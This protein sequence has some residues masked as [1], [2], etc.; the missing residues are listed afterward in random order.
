SLYAKVDP[1]TQEKGVIDA[2]IWIGYAWADEPRN[3]AVVMVTGDDKNQVKESAEFLANSFWAVR[4][5]FEF[6]APVAYLDESLEMALKSE[7]KP[8]VIS[9]MGD[10]PTAGGA[11]DVT[12]TLN[13]L[14]KRPEFKSES[15]PELIYASIPGPDLVA[16]AKEVGIGNQ[17][18]GYAGA[19]VDDRFAPPLLLKGKVLA[20]KEGDSDAK[21]E[22]VVQIGSI[23]VIVTE[24][25]KPY[26]HVK[27]FTDLNLD[28]ENTD[29][30]VVKIGYLVPE[31]YDLRGDWIMALTPGGVDQD[32]GRLGYQRIN[33]PMF[34]LDKDMADPDLSV[35]WVKESGK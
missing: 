5:E 4:N 17:V 28:P 25:R 1:I 10:N 32:L 14:L 35:R 16:K 29:I 18:E 30:L 19:M 6:V 33:R 23:K 26:H 22:V 2:A 31:L 11:G 12:W 21:T 34:P 24:K 7:K 13:E 15:G 9:D 27:D 8:F 20:I 3:H